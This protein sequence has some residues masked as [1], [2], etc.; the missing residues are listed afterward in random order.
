MCEAVSEA[1]LRLRPGTGLR[2]FTV[3][4]A[5]IESDELLTGRWRL[6]TVTLP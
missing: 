4:L 6:P 3:S 2:D 5:V 1:L